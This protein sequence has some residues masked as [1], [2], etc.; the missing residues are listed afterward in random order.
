MGEE[1]NITWGGGGGGGGRGCK[2]LSNNPSL[3]TICSYYNG[4]NCAHSKILTVGYLYYHGI[5]VA[6]YC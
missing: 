2:C 3:S 4:I 1:S 6:S 5:A